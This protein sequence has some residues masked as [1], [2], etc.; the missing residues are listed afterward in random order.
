MLGTATQHLSA[1][2]DFAMI[3]FADNKIWEERV[4]D[5]WYPTL[6]V[7]VEKTV[8]RRQIQNGLPISE[9]SLPIGHSLLFSICE[10]FIKDGKVEIM[11]RRLALIMT[12]LAVGRAEEVACST[13]TSAFWTRDLY[14]LM[15]ECNEI[16]TAE[17]WI[18]NVTPYDCFKLRRI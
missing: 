17:I 13:W 3:T 16:K 7:A 6:R 5:R 12:F 1:I 15:K 4:L 18:S 11:K 8:N 2:K 10:T 9:S 14:N